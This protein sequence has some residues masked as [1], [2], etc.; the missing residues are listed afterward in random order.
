LPV[1]YS[2]EEKNKYIYLDAFFGIWSLVLST[3]QASNPKPRDYFQ[4]AE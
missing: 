4:L 3:V 2:K 1:T